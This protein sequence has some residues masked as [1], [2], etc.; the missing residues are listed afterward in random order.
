MIQKCPGHRRTQ[1]ALN[2]F[3]LTLC[4]GIQW[5]SFV[6]LHF[7]QYAIKSV[8]VKHMGRNVV[9]ALFGSE[10]ARITTN[11][12]R[13]LIVCSFIDTHCTY[14]TCF[15]RSLRRSSCC[16]WSAVEVGWRRCCFKDCWECLL[17]TGA[18]SM[19]RALQWS[20]MKPESWYGWFP[21]KSSPTYSY[22]WL[23]CDF[24]NK[25]PTEDSPVVSLI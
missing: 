19:G 23:H 21:L 3:K 24:Q 12:V 10:E 8:I 9:V 13:L 22:R 5:L 20:P 25:A 14:T 6:S 4:M 1:K 11:N 15:M 16:Y 18:R 2:I 7:M 17:F